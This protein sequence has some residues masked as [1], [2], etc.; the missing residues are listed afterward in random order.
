MS[1]T[2]LS[3]ILEKCTGCRLHPWCDRMFAHHRMAVQ[4]VLVT[5]DGEMVAESDIAAEQWYALD[6]DAARRFDDIEG[7][8]G[9]MADAADLVRGRTS[10]KPCSGSAGGEAVQKRLGRQFIVH[11]RRRHCTAGGA[12]R[13][14]AL[15]FSCNRSSVGCPR[16][17]AV[18]TPLIVSASMASADPVKSSP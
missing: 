18:L 10:R 16:N 3:D 9:C 4:A 8:V 17:R 11:L 2:D 15:G 12:D 5:V 7:N 6:D 14:K 1:A 13:L